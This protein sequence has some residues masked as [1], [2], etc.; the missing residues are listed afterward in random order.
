VHQAKAPNLWGSAHTRKQI[1]TN[2][3]VHR[4]PNTVA[5]ACTYTTH[6]HIPHFRCT[7]RCMST[8][9]LGG[10]SLATTTHTATHTHTNVFHFRCTPRCVPTPLVA[11]SDTVAKAHTYTHILHFRCTPR[12]VPTP[13]VAHASPMPALLQQPWRQQCPACVLWQ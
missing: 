6:T 2:I 8:H 7:P 11:H 4:H 10:A 1:H 13:L 5:K 12:C 3:H 9:A